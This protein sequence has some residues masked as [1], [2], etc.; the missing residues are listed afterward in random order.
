MG[1]PP[2][3]NLES[4]QKFDAVLVEQLAKIIDVLSNLED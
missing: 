4:D 3:A 1:N 2:I